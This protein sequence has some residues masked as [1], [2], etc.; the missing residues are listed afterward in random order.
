MGKISLVRVDFR[1]IHGQ[2]IAK[3]LKQT[4]ADHIIVIDDNISKNSFLCKVYK[5]SIPSNVTIDIYNVTDALKLWKEGK[6][7]DGNIFIIF[8][9]ISTALRVWKEGFP[10][11]ELQIGGVGGG[12][13]QKNV[14]HNINFSPA[15]FQLL[16]Q[17]YE[18][19][20]KVTLQA[21]PEEKPLDY[22]NVI[23]K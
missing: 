9:D 1:V 7:E 6:M 22:G 23:R 15:D 14:Y 16:N 3:W 2:V 8:K 21:I 5:M 10:I 18:G 17:L 12:A 13:G 20:V 19:G 11:T 4:Q